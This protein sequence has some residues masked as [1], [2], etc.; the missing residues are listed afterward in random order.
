MIA[1]GY[2]YSIVIWAFS[3]WSYVHYLAAFKHAWIWN[4]KFFEH[5]AP[6]A[7]CWSTFKPWIDSIWIVNWFYIMQ[8]HELQNNSCINESKT[9]YFLKSSYFSHQVNWTM[10]RFWDSQLLSARNDSYGLM[11]Y[12]NSKPLKTIEIKFFLN[13]HCQNLLRFYN[14]WSIL[15]NFKTNLCFQN[16][17]PSSLIYRVWNFVSS[18]S[19]I[20][21][22][23]FVL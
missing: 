3:L 22:H 20:I 13:F 21:G 10:K 7:K 15:L 14:A 5:L 9:W 18:D 6:T 1:K 4:A 11:K 8:R 16:L 2:S 19:R 23:F 12:Q 17:G